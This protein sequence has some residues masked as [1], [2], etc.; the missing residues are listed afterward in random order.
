MLYYLLVEEDTFLPSGEDG[1]TINSPS[2]LT[3]PASLGTEITQE[4]NF[5]RI[6]KD[7]GLHS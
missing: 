4:N 6:K 3:N 1:K 2:L 7:A 5:L